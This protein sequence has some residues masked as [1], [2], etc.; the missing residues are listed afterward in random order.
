MRLGA[1]GS[2]TGQ[3]VGD[4]INGGPNQIESRLKCRTRKMRWSLP[5]PT[6]SK[7]TRSTGAAPHRPAFIDSR[8]KDRH[9]TVRNSREWREC[10]R[11]YHARDEES[12][13]V[14]VGQVTP[15]LLSEIS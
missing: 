13:K 7:T 2:S 4:W 6:G 9:L 3:A 1:P 10:T 5:I 12:Q 15:D 14:V 8:V 11:I